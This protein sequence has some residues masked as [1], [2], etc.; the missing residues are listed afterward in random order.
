MFPSLTVNCHSVT[1]RLCHYISVS[2]CFCVQ[3]E[4]Q[5]GLMAIHFERATK[6]VHTI[7]IYT[8]TCICEC[9]GTPPKLIFGPSSFVS[10]VCFYFNKLGLGARC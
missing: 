1:L 9:L 4:T 2:L 10:K 5:R 6:A 7:C 3:I 8:Y